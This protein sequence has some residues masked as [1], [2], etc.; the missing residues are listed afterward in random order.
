MLLSKAC[1]HFKYTICDYDICGL[2]MRRIQS[3]KQNNYYIENP[4]VFVIFKCYNWNIVD[5]LTIRYL[6]HRVAVKQ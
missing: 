3:G 1:R 4:H 5:M 2:S 6:L